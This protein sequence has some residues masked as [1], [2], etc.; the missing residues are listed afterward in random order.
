L[1]IQ[2]MLKHGSSPEQRMPPLTG[3]ESLFGHEFWVFA[4]PLALASTDTEAPQG[5]Q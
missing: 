3:R 5:G 2:L 1:D 4:A